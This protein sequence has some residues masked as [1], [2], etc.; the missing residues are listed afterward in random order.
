MKKLLFFVLG[1]I[2]FKS[3]GQNPELFGTWYLT[4]YSVDLEEPS[5]ISN[6]QP[7]ISPFLI[8]EETLD[9]SG[10]AACNPY[11]GNFGYDSNSNELILN[12]FD[13]TLGLCDFEEHNFFEVA[14]FSYFN[15]G[16]GYEFLLYIDNSGNKGL[17]LSI[18]PGYDLVYQEHPLSV[19]ENIL[20]DL[21][22]YPNPVSD[23]L[24]ITSEKSTIKT[25]AVFSTTGQKVLEIEGSSNSIDVSSLSKGIY[26]LEIN[27]EEGKSVQKFIKK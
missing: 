24:F 3:F 2:A 7:P 25:M 1:F 22:I 26:F 10:E 13:T 5:Y 12:S 4:S 20:N 11:I 16:A 18:D 15:V 17:I 6:I 9:F 27:S 19:S 23:Q 8:I 21:R 14:Y